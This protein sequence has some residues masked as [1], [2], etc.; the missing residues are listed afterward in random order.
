MGKVIY[1]FKLYVLFIIVNE[2]FYKVKFLVD[3]NGY[4]DRLFLKVGR[5]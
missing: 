3:W 1:L 4:C 2:F 5:K